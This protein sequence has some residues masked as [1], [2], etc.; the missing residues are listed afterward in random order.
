MNPWWL[1][2]TN[3]S[4]VIVSPVHIH[5]EQMREYLRD[6]QQ[7]VNE[8]D[9]GRLLMLLKE[10]IPILQSKLPIAAKRVGDAV[11]SW[12]VSLWAAGEH[13]LSG[14]A[15]EGS[16]VSSKCQRSVAFWRP[17]RLC[18]EILLIRSKIAPFKA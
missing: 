7:I 8:Q 3:R 1:P 10:L 5:A 12:R 11:E 15:V 4:E 2:R 18:A 14:G 13:T 17:L 16:A 9:I 6:L